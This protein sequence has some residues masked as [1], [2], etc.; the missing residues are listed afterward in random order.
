MNLWINLERLP[1][2]GEEVN[3]P[4]E[5]LRFQRFSPLQPCWRGDLPTEGFGT[6]RVTCQQPLGIRCYTAKRNTCPGTPREIG[7][8]EVGRIKTKVSRSQSREILFGIEPCLGSRIAG[9][10]EKLPA[11]ELTFFMTIPYGNR[12]QNARAEVCVPSSPRE[13]FD[14]TFIRHDLRPK[15]ARAAS[16]MN[17]FA[18]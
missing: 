2:F 4:H 10:W 12:L 9:N 5:K 3:I 14:K 7:M 13:H 8:E 1:E 15:N 16:R 11:R 18:A 6:M 17:R